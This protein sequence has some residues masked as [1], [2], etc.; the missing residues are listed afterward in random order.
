MLA[1][2]TAF[3]ILQERRHEAD[4]AHDA[5]VTRSAAVADVD[6]A[7]TLLERTTA[8]WEAEDSLYRSFL[9][10][11]FALPVVRAR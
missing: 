8:V 9:L 10:L 4:C 2:A 6:R 11:A 3:S 1:V 5:N 7:E